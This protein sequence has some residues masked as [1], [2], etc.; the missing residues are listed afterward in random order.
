MA[1]I[2]PVRLLL[3]IN[4]DKL[5]EWYAC[6][7]SIDSGFVRAEMVR[8]A[9]KKIRP[10]NIQLMG[11]LPQHEE[12][13][14]TP[15][16]NRTAAIAAAIESP[17]QTSQTVA[18]TDSLPTMSTSSESQPIKRAQEEMPPDAG[19]VS[20]G[21]ELGARGSMAARIIQGGSGPSWT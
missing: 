12:K 5:P 15:L 14:S 20:G 11:D 9:L 6:L 2:K 13:E 18:N 17:A 16:Q 8:K 1:K 21:E 4:A 3:T 19:V 7:Q 10:E